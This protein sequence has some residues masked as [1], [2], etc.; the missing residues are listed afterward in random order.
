MVVWALINLHRTTSINRKGSVRLC[1]GYLFCR[2]HG[3]YNTRCKIAVERL[4]TTCHVIGRPGDFGMI[5]VQ[6]KVRPVSRYY[7]DS[8]VSVANLAQ[9]RS[10]VFHFFSSYPLGIEAMSNV[11]LDPQ[12]V[13]MPEPRIFPHGITIAWLRTLPLSASGVSLFPWA[14]GP[15]VFDEDVAWVFAE[16]G[17]GDV[18]PDA[19][20]IAPPEPVPEPVAPA[21]PGAQELLG[22]IMVEVERVGLLAE[23]VEEEE[24]EQDE[25]EW[26][27][28]HHKRRG[29][30]ATIREAP[31][32]LAFAAARLAEDPRA[33]AVMGDAHGMLIRPP[34]TPD[35]EDRRMSKRFWE[36]TVM[37]WRTDLRPW[38]PPVIAAAG[39][40]PAA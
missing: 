17:L 32:Y 2:R 10:F 15:W 21:L 16:D 34:V 19:V 20:P 36:A 4:Y 23:E 31:A 33:L 5:E 22:L 6:Q 8:D 37:N 18:E 12:W 7:Y 25:G 40:P 1:L 24:E 11:D 30:I 35:P 3:D 38:A 14:D 39:V 28:R 9:L 29:A 13:E 26:Q 27:R